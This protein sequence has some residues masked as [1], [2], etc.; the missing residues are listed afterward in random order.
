MNDTVVHYLT[1]Q[2]HADGSIHV[3][4][5]TQHVAIVTGIG[6]FTDKCALASSGCSKRVIAA[7][8]LQPLAHNKTTAGDVDVHCDK[9]CVLCNKRP[10]TIVQAS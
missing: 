3:T 8:C 10:A 5:C 7:F 9:N 2:V 1:T 6:C 4:V